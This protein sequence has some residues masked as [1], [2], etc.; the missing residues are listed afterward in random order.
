MVQGRI[1]YQLYVY[2]SLDFD[3]SG[4]F[5]TICDVQKT[6]VDQQGGTWKMEE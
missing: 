3:H 1:S 5:R 2:T 6:V 4:I